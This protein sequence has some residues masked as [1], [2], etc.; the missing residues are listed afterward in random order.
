MNCSFSVAFNTVRVTELQEYN[1][2]FLVTAELIHIFQLKL[3]M[4]MKP[5]H[6]GQ[7][8]I[9]LHYKE[10]DFLHKFKCSAIYDLLDCEG[11]SVLVI[12]MF[13]F[14]GKDVALRSEVK[15]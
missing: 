12:C 11:L 15:L 9:K 2:N 14:R 5:F 10:L 6:S 4:V 3:G 7:Q 13:K 8:I 1:G